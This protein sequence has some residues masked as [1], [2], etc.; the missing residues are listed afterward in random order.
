[1]AGFGV[2]ET[3]YG[4]RFEATPEIEKSNTSKKISI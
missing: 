4:G 1:L 3:T 2:G